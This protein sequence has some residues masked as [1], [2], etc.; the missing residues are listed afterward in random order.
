MEEE[1]GVGLGLVREDVAEVGTEDEAERTRDG[2]EEEDGLGA[3]EERKGVSE[4][5]EDLETGDLGAAEE[6]LG[7]EDVGLRSE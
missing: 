5:E 3:K 7:L 1:S 6:E 4:E 2:E